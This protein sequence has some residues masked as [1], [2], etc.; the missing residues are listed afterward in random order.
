M[1]LDVVSINC[2]QPSN[3]KPGLQVC[4]RYVDRATLLQAT[5]EVLLSSSPSAAGTPAEVQIPSVQNQSHQESC[6]LGDLRPIGFLQCNVLT[7][8]APHR[9]LYSHSISSLNGWYLTVWT[10]LC[11]QTNLSHKQLLLSDIPALVI[12]LVSRENH[13]SRGVARY[14]HYGTM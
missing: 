7:N 11:T 13:T 4:A 5:K 6:G 3:E 2:I 1:R 8:C 12:A 14:V 9:R 10:S